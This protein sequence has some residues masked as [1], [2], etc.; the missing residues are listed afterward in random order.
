[1]PPRIQIT[2]GQ[3]LVTRQ[4]LRGFADGR[5]QLAVLERPHMSR[6]LKTHGAGVFKAKF[7]AYDSQGAED[8]WNKLESRFGPALAK[9]RARTAL[10]DPEVVASLKDLLALH[11]ARSRAIMVAREPL[12]A[13]LVADHKNDMLSERPDLL[14]QALRTEV[15]VDPTGPGALQWMN[16]RAHDE[17]VAANRSKWDSDRNPINFVAAR[18]HFER[19]HVQIGYSDDNNLLIGDAPV[20]TTSRRKPGAGPHQGVALRD[21][22]HVAMPI[23]PNIILSLGPAPSETSLTPDVVDW[24]NSQQWASYIDW[25]AAL[26]KSPADLELQAQTAQRHHARQPL[27]A[28]PQP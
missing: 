9:V 2:D 28:A 14:A 21:A 27:I 16:E 23:A 25:I 22:D 1:M 24:Y 26:P 4:L 18:T 20:I 3:H 11:W 15:G 6:K 7:D 5:G 8:R 12:V 17:V 10:A 13:Q 19:F